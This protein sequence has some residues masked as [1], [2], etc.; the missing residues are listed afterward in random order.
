MTEHAQSNNEVFRVETIFC[1]I[2]IDYISIALYWQI[3]LDAKIW[4]LL[5]IV[6]LDA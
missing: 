3:Y 4:M 1:M 5:Y 6:L 2:C